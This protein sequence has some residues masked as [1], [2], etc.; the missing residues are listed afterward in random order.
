MDANANPPLSEGSAAVQAHLSILQ[1]IVL[2]MATNSSACKAWCISIV[3]A[4]LV[5]V[6]DKGKPQHALIALLPT[7]LFLALDAYYLALEKHFRTAY[8]AFVAKVHSGAVRPVD[9]F[10]IEPG[11]T[12]K[13]QIAALRSFSVWAFYVPLAL[14][15]ELTRRFILS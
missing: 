10:S 2:R 8:N 14:M 13:E 4:I 5:L 15:I 1:A 12:A 6:A 3:S 9:V 7:L 11:I